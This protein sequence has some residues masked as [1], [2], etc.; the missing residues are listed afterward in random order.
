MILSIISYAFMF[1]SYITLE[2]MAYQISCAAYNAVSF[3]LS[4]AVVWILMGVINGSSRG[5]TILIRLRNYISDGLL[6]FR[7][8]KKALPETIWQ[9]RTAHSNRTAER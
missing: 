1:I 9:T 8:H 2:G 6:H 3:A 7:L 4:I 5:D